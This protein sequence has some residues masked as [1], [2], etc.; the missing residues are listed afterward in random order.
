MTDELTYTTIHEKK[1]I[2]ILRRKPESFYLLE[3]YR[4][5]LDLR[6]VWDDIDVEEVRRYLDEV[7]HLKKM[8]KLGK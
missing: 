7:M 1:F 2:D 8:E 4:R 5:S 6:Q 3:R